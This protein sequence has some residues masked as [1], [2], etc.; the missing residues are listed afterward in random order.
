MNNYPQ[1]LIVDDELQIRKLLNISLTARQFKVLEANNGREAISFSETLKPDAVILDLGLPDM[2]GLE[3][4]KKIR[5][6]SEVPIIILSVQDDSEVIVEALGLGADDYVTKPFEPKEL[7]ARVN[8]CLRR[9]LK[10]ESA[11]VTEINGIRID[12][13]SRLVFKDGIEVKLTSTEYDLL[14]LFIKNP[15]KILTNR[16]ILKDVWGPSSVD[17]L[18][19]PRVYVRHLRQKLEKN[20]DEPILFITESG[21]GYRFKTE[22]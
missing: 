13:G 3:V 17:N 15:N 5:A 8:V 6:F 12:L 2:S 11:E 19:Y 22:I 10:K 20:P 21:V 16:Q 4:L 7:A 18:Q 14:K 1:I 9:N